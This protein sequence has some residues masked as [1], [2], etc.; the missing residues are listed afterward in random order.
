MI[1]GFIGVM[2]GVAFNVEGYYAQ[3][4]ALAVS[5]ATR[6]MGIGTLLVKRAEEWSIAQGIHSMGVNSGLQRADT[7]K[8]YELNGYE[9]K[10][11]SFSKKLT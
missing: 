2:K 10:S 8:F 5:S 9:K 4:M 3:I 11:S 1:V 7:H 6:R